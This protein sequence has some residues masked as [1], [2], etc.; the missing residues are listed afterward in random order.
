MKNIMN[1]K[2]YWGRNK[3]MEI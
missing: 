3:Q 2:D 1:Y